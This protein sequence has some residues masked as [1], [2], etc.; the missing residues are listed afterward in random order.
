MENN[1][2]QGNNLNNR[3]GQ[4]NGQNNEINT[5]SIIDVLGR[6][7]DYFLNTFHNLR[8]ENESLK[9]RLVSIDKDLSAKDKQIE[10]LK[11]ENQAKEK[12]LSEIIAK[13][14]KILN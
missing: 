10:N 2:P 1:R 4:Q 3:S 11:K 8:E 13:L 5:L 14:E 12:E 7:I 6:K 9:K